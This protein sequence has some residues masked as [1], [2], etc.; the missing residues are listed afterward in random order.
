MGGEGVGDQRTW[1]E[2]AEG[3]PELDDVVGREEVVDRHG[4]KT[5][6]DEPIEGDGVAATLCHRPVQ[7]SND[8]VLLPAD[9]AEVSRR[10]GAPPTVQVVLVVP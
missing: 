9:A 10:I 3:P 1:I 6:V 2:A 4:G 7:R 8:E 5:G